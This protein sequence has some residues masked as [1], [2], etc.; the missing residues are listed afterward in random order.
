MQGDKS[1]RLQQ[2]TAPQRRDAQV[3]NLA[4]LANARRSLLNP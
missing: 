1:G 3:Q 2:G 4:C